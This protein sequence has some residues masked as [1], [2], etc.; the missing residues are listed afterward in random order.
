VDYL[1]ASGGGLA[2][3]PEDDRALA[4]AIRRL[5]ADEPLRQKM[6]AAARHYFKQHIKVEA[7][8]KIIEDTIK[9]GENPR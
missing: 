3:P 8:A 9:A 6:G 5:W 1:K 4:A 2:T 7:A